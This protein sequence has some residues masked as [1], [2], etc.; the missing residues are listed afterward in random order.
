M[1]YLLSLNAFDSE[2]DIISEAI[3]NLA[4]SIKGDKPYRKERVRRNYSFDQNTVKTMDSLIDDKITRNE[5]E[6]VDLAI[7]RFATMYRMRESA[8][9]LSIS[10]EKETVTSETKG[11]QPRSE[12]VA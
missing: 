10:E 11:K 12:L 3:S 5:C 8:A 1:K 2:T 9:A 6:V 7:E 4:S